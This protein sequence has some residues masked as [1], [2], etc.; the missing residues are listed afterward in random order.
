M[1]S[2]Y[3]FFLKSSSDLSPY[4]C[5]WS[6]KIG[7]NPY[8]TINIGSKIF[9]KYDIVN[10]HCFAVIVTFN[11]EYTCIHVYAHYIIPCSVNMKPGLL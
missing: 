5:T 6:K 9:S 8:A 10:W 3:M 4:K 1:K 7:K 2:M 11:M